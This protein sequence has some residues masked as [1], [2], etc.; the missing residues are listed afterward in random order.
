[1]KVWKTRGKVFHVDRWCQG[2]ERSEKG[3]GIKSMDKETA[4]AWGLE[5]C[6][7][8]AGEP[9]RKQTESKWGAFVREQR[10][11]VK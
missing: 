7:K 9:E 11:Q 5:A 4:E 6:K 3:R 8:C 1:M 2:L 10:E